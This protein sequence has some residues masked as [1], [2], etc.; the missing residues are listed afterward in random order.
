VP[1][2]GWIIEIAA[3]DVSVNVVFYGGADLDPAAA[4]EK[5]GPV[6]Q[7]HHLGAGRVPRD[8][9]VDQAGRGRVPGWK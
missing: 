7:D 8:A 4:P 6:H 5:G 2:L 9:K 3:Y 1:K